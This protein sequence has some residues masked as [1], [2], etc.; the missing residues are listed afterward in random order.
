MSRIINIVVDASGSMA[1]D[2]KNAVVKYLINS[3]C[4]VIQTEEFSDVEVVLFQWAKNSIRFENIEKAKLEFKG[5]ASYDDFKPT[6]DEI[7]YESPMIL[8]S[9]GGFSK[10]DKVKIEKMSRKIIPIFIGIDANRSILKD[11]A[12][13]KVVYSV[14]DF[15]QALAETR[16]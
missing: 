4:N 1:E 10:N 9:D 3:I 15:M 12:T 5:K 6:E 16:M 7:E 2:D 13:D 8:I 14:V 11:I